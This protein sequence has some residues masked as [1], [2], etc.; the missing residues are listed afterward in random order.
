MKRSSLRRFVSATLVSVMVLGTTITGSA[1]TTFSDVNG[2]WAIASINYGVANG[3]IKGYA[4]GTFKPDSPVT[5]AEFSKM[6]NVS[7]GIENI[8]AIGFSDVYSNDWYYSDV[9]KAVAA[10]YINV[11]NPLLFIIGC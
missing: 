8:Q 11:I 3:F 10:G 9:R 1:A 6:L 2:H 5:R 7:Y 4:D